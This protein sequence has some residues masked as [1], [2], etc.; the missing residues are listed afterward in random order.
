MAFTWG[1]DPELDD[2]TA[3]SLAVTTAFPSQASAEAWF[4]QHWPELE[5]AGVEAVTLLED[6][7]TVYGPMPLSA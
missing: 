2:E 5:D 6:G 7:V 1:T 4:S 3:A